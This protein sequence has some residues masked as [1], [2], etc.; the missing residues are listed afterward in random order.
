MMQRSVVPS[1]RMI[2]RTIICNNIY[3]LKALDMSAANSIQ[4]ADILETNQISCS[5]GTYQLH[6]WLGALLL[7]VL[8]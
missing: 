3:L 2:D 6:K 4:K 5:F 7:E 1:T 8:A